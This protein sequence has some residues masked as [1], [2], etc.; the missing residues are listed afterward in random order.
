[1]GKPNPFFYSAPPTA[2]AAVH[3]HRCEA[4]EL[5]SANVNGAREFQTDAKP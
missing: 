4:D 3:S 5:C 1:M 2:L